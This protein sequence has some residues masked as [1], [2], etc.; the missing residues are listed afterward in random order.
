M[1]PGVYQ[2]CV[3]LTSSSRRPNNPRPGPARRTA[4]WWAA[5]SDS[6]N[7]NQAGQTPGHTGGCCGRARAL[8]G[9]GRAGQR[10]M[11]ELAGPGQ[12]CGAVPPAEPMLGCNWRIT[13]KRSRATAQI[14][15]HQWAQPPAS[16][17]LEGGERPAGL[18]P[19]LV[20]PGAIAV[21]PQPRGVAPND[22]PVV[23]RH[24]HLRAC[25]VRAGGCGE[26]PTQPARRSA[27]LPR[28]GDAV[29]LIH[30]ALPQKQP[31]APCCSPLA[32]A[33]ALYVKCCVGFQVAPPSLLTH[34]R[35]QFA[36][37][38]SFASSLLHSDC[39]HASFCRGQA[40][41]AARN[42]QWQPALEA[43]HVAGMARLAALRAAHRHSPLGSPSPGMPPLRSPVCRSCGPCQRTRA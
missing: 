42:Q 31:P 32:A 34:R 9:L 29:C 4:G 18:Y 12:A 37:V 24:R 36:S 30:A 15:P 28:G 40:A 11:P 20:H 8:A 26:G 27:V 17:R 3:F 41:A 38:S 21:V 2:L 6:P 25:R 35:P 13:A 43:Q 5:T 23:L 1:Q 33:P 22:A 39:R 10:A 16:P 14:W 7:H 19:S